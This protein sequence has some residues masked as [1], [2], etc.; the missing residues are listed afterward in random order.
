MIILDSLLSSSSLLMPSSLPDGGED[1]MMQS[2][3]RMQ[4]SPDAMSGPRLCL[5][6][7]VGGSAKM[8]GG[9]IG[10]EGGRDGEY[11]DVRYVLRR[12]PPTRRRNHQPLL[13]TD[14]PVH[15]PP[16]RPHQRTGF[17]YVAGGDTDRDLLRYGGFD[18]VCE[19]GGGA[20]F[21]GAAAESD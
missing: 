14:H 2:L 6:V 21:M 4:R 1:S 17:H 20:G 5:R 19:G 3:S 11:D 10:G 12:T 13:P 15:L 8:R 9:T 16:S 18:R 7:P